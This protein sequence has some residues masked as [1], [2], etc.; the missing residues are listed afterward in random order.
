MDSL[1]VTEPPV[2][3]IPLAKIL[4]DFV[5]DPLEHV[6]QRGQRRSNRDRT[7]VH[8]QRFEDLDQRGQADIHLPALDQ[9][10][11]RRRDAKQIGEL[12]LRQSQDMTFSSKRCSE[13]NSYELIARKTYVYSLNQAM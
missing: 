1:T 3:Q 12:A 6:C 2:S 11:T 7:E 10:Q 4:Q 9:R 13:L 5:G 8:L